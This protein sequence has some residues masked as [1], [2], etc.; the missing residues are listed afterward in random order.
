MVAVLISWEASVRV[1]TSESFGVVARVVCPSK[2]PYL[3]RVLITGK[4]VP[5]VLYDLAAEARE[6]AVVHS[7]KLAWVY[8]SVACQIGENKAA[9]A[10]RTQGHVKAGFEG[11]L[12]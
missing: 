6:V 4:G 3:R 12:V 2:T 9:D 7:Q 5:E 11:G 8:T 10:A 1:I